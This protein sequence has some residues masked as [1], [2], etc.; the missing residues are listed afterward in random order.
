ML[1][2]IL[3]LC[4]CMG[5]MNM[6]FAYE[7][8]QSGHHNGGSQF[9]AQEIVKP[10]K[11]PQKFKQSKPIDPFPATTRMNQ[12]KKQMVEIQDEY[13]LNP[14][15]RT[16]MRLQH[17]IISMYIMGERASMERQQVLLSHPELSYRA[18]NPTESNARIINNQL[19]NQKMERAVNQLAKTHGLLF[20]YS[21]QDQRAINLAPSLV[22]F[23]KAHGFA[24]KGV[25]LTNQTLSSIPDNFTDINNNR[26][27]TKQLHITSF[28]TLFLNNPK[29]GKY[30]P[31]F[32]GYASISEITQMMFIIQTNFNYKDLFN[33]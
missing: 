30:Q 3:I 25:P 18:S 12:I 31:V 19:K 2:R 26:R 23:A 13:L 15:E 7:I 16:T 11:E 27:I 33:D 20:F 24:F 1:L 6:S 21:A 14:T 32:Y 5:M 29:T 8:L 28:P 4:G 10:K 22:A 9:Y 17:A